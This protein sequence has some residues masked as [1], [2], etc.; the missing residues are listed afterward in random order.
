MS[1]GNG[2]TISPNNSL[3]SAEETARAAAAEYLPK[4]AKLEEARRAIFL[5][6]LESLAADERAT[7]RRY[8]E[9]KVFG[10]P[11]P[12]LPGDDVGNVIVCDD[13][14]VQI[15]V[16]ASPITQPAA[17]EP[18]SSPGVPAAPA[19]NTP[20]AGGLTWPKTAA[21]AAALLGAGGAGVGV[22]WA[23]GAFKPA[24]NTTTTLPGESRG[25]GIEVIEGGASR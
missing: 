11:M 12:Q 23:L 4:M 22:P 18:T 13:Y 21:L 10:N 17:V 7:V 15:G 5:Q 3:P 6:D 14:H 25:L 9:S 19:A 24:T 1:S 8:R 16:P 2:A 20:A